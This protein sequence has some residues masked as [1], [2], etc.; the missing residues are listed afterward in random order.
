MLE[1]QYHP[2]Q[3]DV[4]AVH[5]KR[6]MDI[7][8]SQQNNHF[9]EE[10]CYRWSQKR[11]DSIVTALSFYYREQTWQWLLSP[12]PTCVK[13]SSTSPSPSWAWASASCIA[14]PTPLK[15]ASSPSWTPWLLTSGSTSS[16][17][18]W[19]LVASFL[20]LPGESRSYLSF[21][22]SILYKIDSNLLHCHCRMS[23]AAG[24]SHCV[25]CWVVIKVVM[26][27]WALCRTPAGG[28]IEKD[29]SWVA[30][31]YSV[32]NV[33][34]LVLCFWN[35]ICR[36]IVYLIFFLFFFKYTSV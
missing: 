33:L 21:V 23:T 32:C 2:H 15:M 27:A 35:C 6:C 14:N 12:S 8:L 25:C 34:F 31:S 29:F 19:V 17:P 24:L 28:G 3:P 1:D 4:I 22:F 16:W 13:R 5:P 20:S 36:K 26:S 10:H 11:N 7:S 30:K 18:T 9:S